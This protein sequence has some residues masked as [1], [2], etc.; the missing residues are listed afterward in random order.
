MPTKS[1]RASKT[2]LAYRTITVGLYA[3]S[4]GKRDQSMCF[5]TDGKIWT[6]QDNREC[7]AESEASILGRSARCTML[8]KD[9]KLNKCW[10]LVASTDW[11]DS[12]RV[13]HRNDFFSDLPRVADSRTFFWATPCHVHF[14]DGHLLLI[15]VMSAMYCQMSGQTFF[16]ILRLVWDWLHLLRGLR[17]NL[18]WHRTR[19]RTS[20]MEPFSRA[21]CVK[22]QW[23]TA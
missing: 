17:F 16:K 22:W 23:R 3:T 5:C 1:L 12:P 21:P 11:L 15:V 2:T 9:Y 7:K 10:R 4:A 13:Q 14:M 18:S 19:W 6:K 20:E 8:Y